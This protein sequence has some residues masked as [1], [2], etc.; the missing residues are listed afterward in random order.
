MVKTLQLPPTLYVQKSTL[1]TLNVFRALDNAKKRAGN[2]FCK[3][4]RH[5]VA[6]Q[7][8]GSHSP[9]KENVVIRERL[10]PCRLTDGKSARLCG[11]D[12]RV[13]IL[14]KVGDHRWKR[15]VFL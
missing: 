9:S 8:E 2:V 10:S 7:P 3:H 15:R 13:G 11:M 14:L 12:V 4:G 5:S 6:H 1:A